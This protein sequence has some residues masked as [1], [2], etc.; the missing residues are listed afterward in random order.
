[1]PVGYPVKLEY[2]VATA[3]RVGGVVQTPYVIDGYRKIFSPLEATI[4]MRA[5]IENKLSRK[6]V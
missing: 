5:G 3:L 1:L 6:D 4:P 2:D